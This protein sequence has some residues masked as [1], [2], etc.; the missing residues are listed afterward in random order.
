MPICTSPGTW[1]VC[2]P[3]IRVFYEFGTWNDMNFPM[4]MVLVFIEINA[5]VYYNLRISFVINLTAS[6]LSIKRFTPRKTPNHVDVIEQDT[7]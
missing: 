3:G 1:K 7:A 2:H 6:T 4:F 5:K